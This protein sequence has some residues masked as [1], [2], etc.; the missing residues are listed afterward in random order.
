VVEDE[1][2]PT[3]GEHAERQETVEDLDVPDGEDEQV[4]GGR[5]DGQITLHDH[6]GGQ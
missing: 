1:Q 2:S 6:A 3:E 4:A 5:S